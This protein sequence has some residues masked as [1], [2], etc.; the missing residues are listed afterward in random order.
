MLSKSYRIAGIV[1]GVLFIA[2][3]FFLFRP[4]L[5]CKMGRYKYEKAGRIAEEM[6]ARYK[7]MPCEDPDVTAAESDRF[8]RRQE[9]LRLKIIR[10]YEQ[11]VAAFS[12]A[13]EIRASALDD[14]ALVAL[15]N[16]RIGTLGTSYPPRHTISEIRQT[17]KVAQA[18][19]EE[20]IRINK[21]NKNAYSSLIQA[22]LNWLH[23][24]PEEAVE[25]CE[26]FKQAFPK[27]STMHFD[28]GCAYSAAGEED[29]GRIHYAKA[30]ELDPSSDASLYMCII[31]LG[32]GKTEEARSLATQY[33]KANPPPSKVW[34]VKDM[35]RQEEETQKLVEDIQKRLTENP[36]DFEATRE[37]A[38]ALSKGGHFD[39]A[40]EWHQKAHS[41]RPDDEWALR[42]LA[43][44]QS[45]RD[46]Q[47]AVKSY[48]KLLSQENDDFSK[49]ID[50]RQ[51]GEAY[52]TMGDYDE[53]LSWYKKAEAKSDFH[54]VLFFR[55]AECYDKMGDEE[56]AEE[57]A[58]K[59]IDYRK[60]MDKKRRY[61]QMKS[62]LAAIFNFSPDT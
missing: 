8:W 17:L 24:N 45:S 53:A 23:R 60:E 22:N 39:L 5:Y 16:S 30:I 38:E 20:A 27:H 35:L 14:E 47:A 26:R 54:A 13:R 28:C 52:Y 18:E 42:R 62:K 40:Y 34:I 51:I 19:L 61:R 2:I 6:A 59:H 46:P 10:C 36:D 31:L 43:D 29:F 7:E 49:A 4:Q 21:N 15:A 12:R 25:A 48:K 55:M 44:F 32:E 9:K 41:I 57:Y 1:I 11:A 58:R 56:M 50:M 3:L 33:I 37:M